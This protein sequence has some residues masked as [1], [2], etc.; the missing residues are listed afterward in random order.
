MS[1][2]KAKGGTGRGTDKKGWNRWGASVKGRKAKKL[3]NNNKMMKG[4]EGTKGKAADKS[5]QAPAKS[6][7]SVSAAKKRD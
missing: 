4:P 2:A 6:E 5:D 3:L 7:G 1:K